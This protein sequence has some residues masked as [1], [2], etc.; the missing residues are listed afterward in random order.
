MTELTQ[1]EP[2]PLAARACIQCGNSKIAEGHPNDLCADCRD[3]FVRYPV[4]QWVWLF[5]GGIGVLLLFSVINLPKNL[6][7]GI[8]LERGKKAVN[9]HKY[10]TAQKEL[11][12]FTRAVPESEEAN[13]YLMIA[14]F[15]NLDFDPMIRAYKRVENKS[16][17]DD[18]LYN[19]V[20]S[21]T[22]T[23]NNYFPS[24]SLDS[25]YTKYKPEDTVAMF[26]GL[27]DY[28]AAHPDDL[29][30]QSNYGSHLMDE[31]QYVAADTV[32]TKLLHEQEDY[33]P[34]LFAMTT[35]K[36]LE[37]KPE[38]AVAYS[39]KLLAINKENVYA[40]STKARALLRENKN[41]EALKT[42]LAAASIKKNDRY[43]TATLA[44]VYHFNKME[45]EKR[46]VIQTKM[47]DKDS[48]ALSYYQ[49]AFDVINRKKEF[50]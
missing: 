15:N 21:L 10:L 35:I 11:E 33:L 45:K 18:D 32:Y 31:E 29:Y 40:M 43:N 14:S 16:I 49:F 41:D 47:I 24:D 34:A 39:D 46:E 20:S 4:P 8:D 9:Q 30:A 3:H 36:R 44:L 26:T 13:A 37:D 17:E 19:K 5:T 12:S 7:L 48:S 2:K 38:E 1:S 42:A 27:K 23:L 50:R 6:S 22:N 25:F 28:V